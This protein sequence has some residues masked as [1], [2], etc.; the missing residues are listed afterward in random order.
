MHPV[1]IQVVH[2]PH[3]RKSPGS[4]RE[5]GWPTVSDIVCSQDENCGEEQQRA[6]VP[7]R[8]GP[9]HRNDQ[10]H[11]SNRLQLSLGGS[12]CLV[13]QSCFIYHLL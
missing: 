4:W 7:V 13:T 3:D 11:S 12:E 9:T 5:V 1:V 2:V 8:V 10:A 6:G